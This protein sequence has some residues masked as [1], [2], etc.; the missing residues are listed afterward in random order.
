MKCIVQSY[1]WTI[2]LVKKELQHYCCDDLT[3]AS[4]FLCDGCNKKLFVRIDFSSQSN[5]TCSLHA[6][7]M[8]KNF[9]VL[10]R[11]AFADRHIFDVIYSLF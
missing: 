4:S 9:T 5:S 2:R 3:Q 7:D 6:Q 11:P 8:P 1:N 10:H